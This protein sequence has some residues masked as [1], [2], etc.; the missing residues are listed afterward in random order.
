MMWKMIQ[1]LTLIGSVLTAGDVEAGLASR[2]DDEVLAV[3]HTG[4][5]LAV[6]V[7]VRRDRQEVLRP[8]LVTVR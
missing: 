6:G 3:D 1:L 8:V 4:A 2:A 5:Q 7:G